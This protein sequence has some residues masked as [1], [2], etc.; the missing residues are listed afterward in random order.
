MEEGKERDH[1]LPFLLASA[2]LHHEL[3]GLDIA[4]AWRLL[5]SIRTTHPHILRVCACVYARVRVCVCVHAC[6][7]ACVRACVCVCV[8]VCVCEYVYVCTHVCVC[9]SMCR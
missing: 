5:L 1:L 9:A 8:C 2:I 3:S 4:A 6:V 7:R